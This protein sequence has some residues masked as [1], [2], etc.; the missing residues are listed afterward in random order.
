M[1]DRTSDDQWGWDLARNRVVRWDDRGPSDQVLGPYPSRTAA[2]NWRQ[3][4][5]DRNLDWEDADE[6]WHGDASRAAPTDG[7]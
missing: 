2:E 3:R 7:D 4:V 6:A 5:E 1:T